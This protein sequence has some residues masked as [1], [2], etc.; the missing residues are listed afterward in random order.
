[1][2]EDTIKI[3]CPQCGKE[4]GISPN[5]FDHVDTVKIECY[6]GIILLVTM[7]KKTKTL[8]IKQ[9]V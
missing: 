9:D 6:D 2:V 5:A 7:D 8:T 1:V 3:K 4:Y